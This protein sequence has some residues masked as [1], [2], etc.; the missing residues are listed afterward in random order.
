MTDPAFVGSGKKAGLELWRIEN[1]A[2]VKLPKV[3]GK[4]HVG[5]SYILLSSTA[6]KSGSLTYAIHFWLGS[7]TSIDEAGV[8]AYKTVELDAA[9]GGGIT[10]YREVQGSESSLFLSYFK[11]TGGVEYLPGGVA[12][13]FKH[14]EKDVYVTRLL[15]LK[16]KRTVR[17]TEVPLTSKSLCK[18]DVFILDAGL[19]IYLFN[20]ETANKME[21]A[22]GIEVASN[23]NSDQRMGRAE[24][25]IINDD[26]KNDG[27]WGPLGGFVDP[28]TLPEG[29]SDD[30]EPKKIPTRLFKVSGEG[31]DVGVSFYFH[32]LLIL[33]L[34]DTMDVFI[35][36]TSAKIFIWVGEK[37]TLEEK[38]QAFPKVV[39]FM[40]QNGI[41]NST[42]VERVAE[43]SES[44][45]FKAE[46]SSWSPPV[47]FG[48]VPKANTKAEDVP[49]SYQH[50]IIY[51]DTPIDDGSGKLKIWIIQNFEKVEI[52][53][54]SYGQFYGGDSYVLLYSYTKNKKEEHIIYFWLGRDSTADEQGTAALMVKELDSDLGGSPVQIRVTQGK[55]P[56]HFRQLFKGKMIVHAGGHGSGF[57]NSTE[58]STINTSGVALYH[59]RGTTALNTYGAEVKAVASSLNSEDCFV[60]GTKGIIYVWQGMKANPD[61]ANVASNIA[62]ILH[63][64]TFKGAD[65]ITVAEG[66]EPSEFWVT[67]GGKTE[68]LSLSPGEEG[69]RPPR[70]FEASTKT[71]TFKVE[72]VDNFDQTDL[73]DEDV[74]LLDTFTQLFVWIGSQSTEEEKSKAFDF[75]KKF[76]EEATDGRDPNIPIIRVQA[77]SEPTIF[78]SQFLIW[79]AEYAAKHTFTDPYQ[80]KLQKLAASKTEAPAPAATVHLKTVTTPEVK[81]AP[82]PAKPSAPHLKHVVPTTT[83]S[84][85]KT[86]PPTTTTTTSAASASTSASTETD[87]RDRAPSV[88]YKTPAESGFFSLDT[89]KAGA[90]AGTDPSKKEE[91][92]DN[93][94][95]ASLFGC[96]KAT[97]V[98]Q[99]KWKRDQKKKELGIF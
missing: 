15:K 86:I 27:F 64:S 13:G 67:L 7:E 53:V 47:S 57:K 99:P 81:P 74:F 40:K 59:I 62:H 75:A 17:I 16:G 70:L 30:I 38:K 6:S 68:Y 93:A 80:L 98:A 9:L 63:N 22:K 19:K 94:T 31:K 29:E 8:A 36:I 55:E 87:T 72:E 46:F 60:L 48:L 34:L 69:P 84:P 37:S 18:G 89:L 25:V 41:P 50:N 20:G 49:V 73:N 44:S 79:D 14:V 35:V 83:A 92:L 85:A 10:Q 61:E 12:S 78:T 39:E 54:E 45:S 58:G 23:I 88:V 51:N 5:D 26:I 21:K 91:Y 82:E 2:P 76:V 3:D 65:I 33:A 11:N 71:G 90:P 77:G 66:S 1:L 42:P 56:P 97:F 96:D 32:N 43:G 52:P 4:F 24:I 28:S 95:F